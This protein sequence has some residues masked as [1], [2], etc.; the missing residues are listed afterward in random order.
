MRLHYFARVDNVFFL[1][2]NIRLPLVDYPILTLIYEV[3]LD[4]WIWH[5]KCELIDVLTRLSLFQTCIIGV[6]SLSSSRTP[7]SSILL[8]EQFFNMSKD[9]RP[10][11]TY[12]DVVLNSLS[13]G[14]QGRAQLAITGNT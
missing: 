12:P 7:A 2:S 11:C 3:C 1:V 8:C 5:K 6:R 13:L 10:Y 14:G 4:L 9:G